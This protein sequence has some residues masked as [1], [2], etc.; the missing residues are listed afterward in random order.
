MCQELHPTVKCNASILNE[1]C[2]KMEELLRQATPGQGGRSAGKSRIRF[3]TI[4]VGTISGTANEIVEMLTRQKD[5]LCCLQETR[6]RGSASL[7]KGNSTIFKS[8]WCG[9]QSGFGVGVMLV[10]K[11]VNNVISVKR[12]NLRCLQ[13][14]FLVGKTIFNFIC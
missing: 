6:W 2:V 11:W 5:D 4:N 14:R 12:Y 10:E 1:S 3:G 7:I 9:D 13:L 8:F